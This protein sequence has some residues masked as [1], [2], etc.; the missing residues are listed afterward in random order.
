MGTQKSNR[1]RN[2]AGRDPR[3]GA[4]EITPAPLILSA[5]I[6][7]FA[8]PISIFALAPS[9]F[10]SAI[11]I[12]L[13]ATTIFLSAPAIFSLGSARAGLKSAGFLVEVW[14]GNG[15]GAFST[16]FSCPGGAAFD[17][18]ACRLGLLE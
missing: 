8:L 5:A 13:M 17:A 2:C 16:R 14:C 6:A 15:V 9:I 18:M 10:S 12:F 11:A 1:Q 7:D 3:F 4:L